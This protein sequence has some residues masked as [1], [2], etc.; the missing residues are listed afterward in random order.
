MRSIHRSYFFELSLMSQLYLLGAV[1][2]DVAIPASYG[3]EISNLSAGRVLWEFPPRMLACFCRRVFLKNF[4]YDFTMGSL[5]LLV[6]VPMFV[7]G[8]IHGSYNWIRY[9]SQGIAAPTG[10]IMIPVL[11]IILGFQLVLAAIGLDLSSVPR[12]PIGRGPLAP[13]KRNASPD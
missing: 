4:I 7:A 3:T 2:R 11:L 6:G 5:Y 8:V 12:E 13:H 10:T 1:I 9:A